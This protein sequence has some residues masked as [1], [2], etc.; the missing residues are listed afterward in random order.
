MQDYTHNCSNYYVKPFVFIQSSG[1]GKSK[2][3]DA[4]GKN[5]LMINFIFFK[6][7][8]YFPCNTKILQLMLLKLLDEVK[9]FVNELP[10][11]KP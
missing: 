2:L 3:V 9:K 11:K 4:F 7:D 5:C 6:N 1:M 10:Q 8:G